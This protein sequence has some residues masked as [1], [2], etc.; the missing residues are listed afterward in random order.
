MSEHRQTTDALKGSEA[1]I[2]ALLEAMPDMILE[3]T[4]EGLITNMIP[5][6]DMDSSMPVDWFI[7][8]QINEVF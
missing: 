7:G 1:R 4:L 8:R 3:I 6:K 5:P 2:R